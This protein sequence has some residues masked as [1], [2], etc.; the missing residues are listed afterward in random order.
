V[1]AELVYG[2]ILVAS[3]LVSFVSIVMMRYY[4]GASEHWFHQWIKADRLLWRPRRRAAGEEYE[5]LEAEQDEL[6]AAAA[7]AELARM[8]A[9]M[10]EMEELKSALW[11]AKFAA[12]RGSRP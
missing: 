7:R 9:H 12:A 4:K 6:D 11:D 3:V 10:N 8:D 1:T 2:L 5:A